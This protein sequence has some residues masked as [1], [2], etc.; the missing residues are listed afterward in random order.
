MKSL[1]IQINGQICDADDE[2][3]IGISFSGFNF[4]E[5]NKI[6]LAYT[7]T[8]SLPITSKNRKIFGF[9]DNY[10]INSIV[11][12]EK[13]YDKYKMKIFVDGQFIFDGKLYVSNVTN[14]RIELYVI[15]GKDFTDTL[16]NVTLYDIATYIVEDL[17]EDLDTLYPN[18]AHFND[19]V[20]YLSTADNKAWIPYTIGTLLNT[21]PYAKT[22]DGVVSL[23]NRYDEDTTYNLENER[24]MCTEFITNSSVVGDFKTGHIYLKVKDI[25]EKAFGEIGYSLN[26]STSVDNAISQDWIRMIDLVLYENLLDNTFVFRADDIYKGS[27][28]DKEGAGF[29][30]KV[31]FLDLFKTICA[32]YALLFDVKGNIITFNT[33]NDIKDNNISNIKISSLKNRKFSIDNI[34]Q[35]NVIGY[36][37]INGS[38]LDSTTI[39]GLLFECK[40]NNISEGSFEDVNFQ[41]NRILCGYFQYEYSDGS[42][43]TTT[44]ALDTSKQNINEGIVI[45]RKDN[46]S[47]PYSVRISRYYNG[48]ETYAVAS[49]YPV[50]E[51]TVGNNGF[52]DV[53]EDSVE[54]PEEIEIDA[55]IPNYFLSQFSSFNYVK[56][57]IIPGF[58]HITKINQWNARLDNQII[59]LNAIR[60]R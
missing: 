32:E 48:A 54:Y 15:N 2:T 57:N 18:G 7:N 37:Q 42:V 23:A 46:D 40:N 10:S 19:I 20:S 5:L 43:L 26:F 14:E 3:A 27:F 30:K 33:L 21:Y 60:I 56:F 59:S 11:A 24:H 52:Y 41:I 35:K 29:S 12:N 4:S 47:V 22:T 13:F 49:L 44:K 58:W 36:S 38:N 25:L 53:F 16:A 51:S 55:Y 31:K 6:H 39:G 34:N 9:P 45:V 8:F 50:K 17:N 28:Q 1:Q